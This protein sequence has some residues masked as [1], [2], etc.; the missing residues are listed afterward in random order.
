MKIVL[1][2]VFPLISDDIY[3]GLNDLYLVML[4]IS[5]ITHTP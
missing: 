1:V 4:P 5:A 2:K 3:T